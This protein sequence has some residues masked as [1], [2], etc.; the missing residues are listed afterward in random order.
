[1]KFPFEICVGTLKSEYYNCEERCKYY[2]SF[3]EYLKPILQGNDED[4]KAVSRNVLYT[5]LDVALRLIHPYMPFISEELYQRLPRRTDTGP[6]SICV[7]PYPIN[8]EV[9]IVPFL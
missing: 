9:R 4:L 1:M 5:C 3:Q 7:T 6:P 2:F 8:E